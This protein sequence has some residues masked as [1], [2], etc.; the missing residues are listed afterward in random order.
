M[1]S[2]KRLSYSGLQNYFLALNW[3]YSSN[4][5]PD[6]HYAHQQ[7]RP[8]LMPTNNIQHSVGVEARLCHY[9]NVMLAVW[10]LIDTPGDDASVS[11]PWR[12]TFSNVTPVT[13]DA[14]SGPCRMTLP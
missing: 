11:S 6:T 12:M 5:P 8:M 3:L 13:E 9:L 10:P 7:A 2:E 14:G 4:T 1:S